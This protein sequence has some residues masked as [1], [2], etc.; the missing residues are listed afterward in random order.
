MSLEAALTWKT[1][2]FG[3]TK[4]LPCTDSLIYEKLLNYTAIFRS[5]SIPN[6][7]TLDNWVCFYLSE[8]HVLAEV[9]DCK[10]CFVLTLI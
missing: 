3:L 7:K 2:T 1:C 5:F 10:S 9:A 6:S 8:R 4:K